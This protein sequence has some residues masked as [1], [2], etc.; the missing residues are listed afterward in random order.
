MPMHQDPL[1]VVFQSA[2]YHS[3]IRFSRTKFD[4][5]CYCGVVG[6]SSGTVLLQL[7]MRAETRATKCSSTIIPLRIKF[8]F[9]SNPNYDETTATKFCTCRDSCA[10]ATCA[11][12]CNDQMIKDG[13]TAKC[14]F[15]PIWITLVNLLPDPCEQ[16]WAEMLRT[17]LRNDRRLEII[18]M[19]VY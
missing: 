12:I 4:N 9:S 5:I 7:R 10:V 6:L 1:L 18:V 11:K 3:E 19:L 15:H 17:W 14:L 16:V 13:F 2:P 8:Q